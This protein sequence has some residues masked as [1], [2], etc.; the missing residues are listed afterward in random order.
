MEIGNIKCLRNLDLSRNKFSGTF[1][2]NLNELNEHSNFNI[3]FNPFLAGRIQDTGQFSFLGNPLLQSP[4]FKL[5]DQLPSAPPSNSQDEN[6][7]GTNGGGF[8]SENG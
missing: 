6:E 4:F 5:D 3:S 8:E 1:P 7:F 2:R